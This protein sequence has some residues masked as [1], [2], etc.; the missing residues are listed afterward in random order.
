[1]RYVSDLE[2]YSP[3]EQH[4]IYLVSEV[5]S[6]DNTV[7]GSLITIIDVS[8]IHFINNYHK[9]KTFYYGILDSN[10]T[11][12][13][14][15][16]KNISNSN[17][18]YT[19]VAESNQLSKQYDNN[20]NITTSRIDK[21]GLYAFTIT[22]NS[23]I[24]KYTHQFYIEISVLFLLIILIVLIVLVWSKFLIS[25]IFKLKAA[26]ENLSNGD[27]SVR[28]N[29]SGTDEIAIAAMAFDKMAESIETSD[30][31]KT[32]FFTNISHE[33][34]TPLNV[35]FSI[36]QLIE[37]SICSKLEI[38][39]HDMV[40]K[41]MKIVRQNC[42]RMIRLI[43]NLT[44]VSK[45]ENGYLK[46]NFEN[47]NIVSLV[48]DI[49]LSIVRYAEAN[50]IKLVFDTT[51][52][53]LIIACDPEKIEK[54]ILNLLSNALKFTG[55]NGS[56]FVNLCTSEKNVL[57]TV[58]DTGVGIPPEKLSVIFERFGQV[59]SSTH[60]KNEGSGIGLSL[61]NALVEAHKGKLSVESKLGEGTS[62]TVSL[63]IYQ[64]EIE[65]S[66]TKCDEFQKSNDLVEKINIEFSDI[67][68]HKN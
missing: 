32:Q 47:H 44:D 41:K 31:L 50:K 68:G 18:K 13:Y 1:M 65:N 20:F 55:E 51:E 56:I 17:F 35:I 8:K 4:I 45:Y 62:F 19:N 42:Y 40:A 12:I 49:T 39:T 21:F 53:E 29:I 33:F 58:T 23:E 57:I 61:A 15:N 7:L 6:S 34:K 64:L 67:Y 22:P 36:S 27:Y 11:I 43:N 28:T 54:I 52:E 30:K 59:N 2:H 38:S 63:P 26:A 10:G 5:K 3:E 16:A 37:N 66:Q 48:E 60:R 24:S 9:T 14:S 46:I 25:P